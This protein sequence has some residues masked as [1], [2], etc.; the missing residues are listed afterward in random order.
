MTNLNVRVLGNKA[1]FVQYQKD[2]RALDAAF[3]DWAT[4]LTWLTQEVRP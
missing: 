3:V 4:F 1:V 2:G